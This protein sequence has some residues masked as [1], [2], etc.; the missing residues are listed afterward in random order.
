MCSNHSC[1][2]MGKLIIWP[3]S[4]SRNSKSWRL[5]LYNRNWISWRMIKAVT[6]KSSWNKTQIWKEAAKIVWT[7]GL[8]LLAQ[9]TSGTHPQTHT[10]KSTLILTDPMAH[11][12]WTWRKV[13]SIATR[14]LEVACQTQTSQLLPTIARM[15]YSRQR[16]PRTSLRRQLISTRIKS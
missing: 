8:V 9:W 4:F 6:S 7:A 1:K 10:S 12:A 5:P 3:S 11:K 15:T 13:Q 14:V 16:T 2:Q